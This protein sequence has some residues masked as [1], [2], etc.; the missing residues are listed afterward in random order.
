MEIFAERMEDVKRKIAVIRITATKQRKILYVVPTEAWHTISIQNDIN[1]SVESTIRLGDKRTQG[2]NSLFDALGKWGAI[3][4][5]YIV[6]KLPGIWAYDTWNNRDV[7]VE[8]LTIHL[9]S[10]NTR[11]QLY[12]EKGTSLGNSEPGVRRKICFDSQSGSNGL[13]FKCGS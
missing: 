5:L 11:I 9:Q 12:P 1:P 3:A 2:F 7:L 8:C 6:F 4:K 13:F 10:I